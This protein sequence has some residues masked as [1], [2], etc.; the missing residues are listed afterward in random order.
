MSSYGN[1]CW[2]PERELITRRLVLAAMNTDD[3]GFKEIINHVETCEDV[4]AVA[5]LL[6]EQ[7][8]EQLAG[9][10]VDEYED[11]CQFDLDAYEAY[12]AEVAKP[13]KAR[14]AELEQEVGAQAILLPGFGIN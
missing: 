7:L 13:I 1:R 8:A 12:V 3:D 10:F 14:I 4:G 5:A 2:T 6:A 9:G 11:T